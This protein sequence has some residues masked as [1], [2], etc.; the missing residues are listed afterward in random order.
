MGGI[1]FICLVGETSTHLRRGSLLGDSVS[2]C[3]PKCVVFCI[4]YNI[5]CDPFTSPYFVS[6]F[7]RNMTLEPTLKYNTFFKP[8]KS[9][10]S[11]FRAI[12]SECD[13]IIFAIGL[14]NLR[15]LS[16]LYFSTSLFVPNN[17]TMSSYFSPCMISGC[18][19]GS[20]LILV[21]F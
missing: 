6:R 16:R 4:V 12:L 9:L 13:P 20:R 3:S 18:K 1:V 15:Q 21:C 10:A 8:Q 11:A 2:T 5:P 19:S 14:P 17:R 7:I